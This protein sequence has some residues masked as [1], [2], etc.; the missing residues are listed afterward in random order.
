MRPRIDVHLSVSFDKGKPPREDE[1]GEVAPNPVQRPAQLIADPAGALHLEGP[2]GSRPRFDLHLIVT[3]AESGARLED[4][5]DEGARSS[6]PRR[7]EE[8]RGSRADG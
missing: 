5:Q 8:G 1:G 2:A 7:R 4:E 6:R 3:T